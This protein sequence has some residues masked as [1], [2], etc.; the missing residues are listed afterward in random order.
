MSR[1]QILPPRVL[2]LKKSIF[3][4]TMY[5]YIILY[6]TEYNGTD[7]ITRI[8]RGEKIKQTQHI[9]KDQLL[10]PK[11]RYSGSSLWYYARGL[12]QPVI[13]FTRATQWEVHLF[14]YRRIGFAALIPTFILLL[15]A[16]NNYLITI[17]F[18]IFFIIQ[19]RK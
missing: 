2:L 5:R 6:T 14:S 17:Y 18:D 19:S 1:L 4:T 9:K 3:Y 13:G 8:L 11:I 15:S 10:R 16:K 7:R 12:K